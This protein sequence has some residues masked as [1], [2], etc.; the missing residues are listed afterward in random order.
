MCVASGLFFIL[1]V[2]L[3]LV[4]STTG[5]PALAVFDGFYRSGA[6]VFGGGH[7]VLPLLQAGTVTPGRVANDRFLAGSSLPGKW[8]PVERRRV[9]PATTVN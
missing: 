7:M 9:M 3:P 6:L 4:R 2:G 8:C 5:N 1:L